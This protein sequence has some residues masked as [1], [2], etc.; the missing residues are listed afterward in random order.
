MGFA[1]GAAPGGGGGGGRRAGGKRGNERRLGDGVGGSLR[2]RGGV[3]TLRRLARTRLIRLIRFLRPRLAVGRRHDAVGHHAQQ[4]ASRDRTHH[5]GWVELA[6]PSPR[7]LLLR[8]RLGPVPRGH[9]HLQPALGRGE[10]ARL[11]LC[12]LG[13]LGGSLGRASPGD[14][15]RLRF[16]LRPFL[17]ARPFGLLFLLVVTVVVTVVV[18]LLKVSLRILL[19]LR[20]GRRRGGLGRRL[21]PC[22][23]LLLVRLG[24]GLFRLFLRASSL[25]PLLVRGGFVE[26]GEE[27]ALLRLSLCAPRGDVRVDQRNLRHVS[28]RSLLVDPR[29]HGVR[30]VHRA[31]VLAAAQKRLLGHRVDGSDELAQIRRVHVSGLVGIL[32]VVAENRAV[33]GVLVEDFHRFSDDVGAAVEVLVAVE[34]P[35][36]LDGSSHPGEVTLQTLPGPPNLLRVKSRQEVILVAVLYGPEHQPLGLPLPAVPVRADR[37]EKIH[38][39][40]RGHRH[41]ERRELLLRRRRSAILVLLQVLLLLFSIVLVP[42]ALTARDVTRRVHRR[43]ERFAAPALERIPVGDEHVERKLFAKLPG[44][45]GDRCLHFLVYFWKSDEPGRGLIRPP[46]RLHRRL[47][48]LRRVRLAAALVQR[49]LHRLGRRRDHGLERRALLLRRPSTPDI[50]VAPVRSPHRHPPPPHRVQ[51]RHPLARRQQLHG[52]ERFLQRLQLVVISPGGHHGDELV[53]LGVGLG[54]G[55]KRSAGVL[56]AILVVLVAA[57]KQRVLRVVPRLLLVLVAVLVLV[58][59]SRHDSRHVNSH[60]SNLVRLVDEFVRIRRVRL[61]GPEDPRRHPHR[62]LHVRVDQRPVVVL[63][64]RVEPVAPRV[65]RGEDVGRFRDV[66]LGVVI[67]GDNLEEVIHRTPL[68]LLPSHDVPGANLQVRRDEPHLPLALDANGARLALERAR[69]LVG[70]GRSRSFPFERAV[71]RGT[72]VRRSASDLRGS[73][74]CGRDSA[75]PSRGLSVALR[76]VMGRGAGSEGARSRRE[77]SRS[78]GAGRERRAGAGVDRRRKESLPRCARG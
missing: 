21:D 19:L 77:V 28:Q 12:E 63:A 5:S 32:D 20:R 40:L 7:R 3:W 33:R 2:R 60:V 14:P 46:H 31:A 57:G 25:P 23:P 75:R 50:R 53:E 18:I 71:V 9:L 54:G 8:R 34:D 41:E 4:P 61:E 24:L 55:G 26:L 30:V 76:V 17:L 43:G 39:R 56:D 10:L 68:A 62:P 29:A 72:A 52:T 78:A 13:S 70:F 45:A 51:P 38:P 27:L 6:R 74:G 48:A 15:R 42:H 58:H 73:R 44:T 35:E 16:S 69:E 66:H 64:R 65:R 49:A 37:F 11:L 1:L 47:H 22:N 36:S 67:D 59:V